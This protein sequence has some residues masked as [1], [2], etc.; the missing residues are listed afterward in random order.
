MPIHPLIP[1][2]TMRSCFKSMSM[3]ASPDHHTDIISLLAR[4][5]PTMRWE[6]ISQSISPL[7]CHFPVVVSLVT[8]VALR[9]SQLPWVQV[10]QAARLVCTANRA[11]TRSHASSPG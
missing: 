7:P 8:F 3:P 5:R 4:S 1:F 9:P 11:R 6:V 2:N 10:D